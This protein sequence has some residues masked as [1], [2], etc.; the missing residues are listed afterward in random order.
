MVRHQALIR[1][2]G[3]LGLAFGVW[4]LLPPYTGPGLAVAARVEF[5]DHVVPG[6]LVI[7][8]AIATLWLSL[9][10][11][12]PASFVFAAGLVVILAGFWM[13]ATHAPLLLQATRGEAPWDATVHHS[14]PGLVILVLGV[15]WSAT[16]WD[17]VDQ[18]PP[19]QAETDEATPPAERRRR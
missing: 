10:R 1:R 4:A 17:D 16:W 13:A 6:M 11:A 7:A 2:L 3:G 9:R 19:D 5:A 14:L 18:Q 15:F 8:I 12:Y